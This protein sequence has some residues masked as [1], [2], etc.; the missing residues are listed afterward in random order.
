[1]ELVRQ[2][3]HGRRQVSDL[4]QELLHLC[5]ELARRRRG[6]LAQEIHLH[7]QERQALAQVVVQLTRDPPGFILLG[8]EQP[9][10]LGRAAGTLELGLRDCP[11]D[12]LPDLSPDGIEHLQERVVTGSLPSIFLSVFQFCEWY[13]CQ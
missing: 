1:V 11:F 6:P 10:S 5:F 3:V 12:E 2:V 13:F 7:R 4:R 9:A 8:L